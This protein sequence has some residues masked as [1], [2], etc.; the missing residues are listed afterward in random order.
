[1]KRLLDTSAYVALKRGEGD[2]LDLVRDSE[3]IVFSLVVIG[4]LLFGF[5]DGGRYRKNIAD[6][7]EFLRNPRVSQIAITRTTAEHFGRIATHLKR[8]GTP[9]PTNDIWIAAQALETGSE[10]VSRD[11]HFRYVPGLIVLPE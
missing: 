7:E 2:M 9:I 11:G 8:Q 3:G 4:E 1:M 10:V 6:L 5:H